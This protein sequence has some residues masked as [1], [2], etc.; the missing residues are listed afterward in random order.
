MD[1]AD[2]TAKILTAKR[3]K[4]LSWKT[5]CA[6]IGGGSPTYLTAACLGQMKLR[7]EQAAKAAK[8]FGLGEEETLLL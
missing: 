4:G 8:L 7:P 3:L 1:R 2:V 5:I 6:E